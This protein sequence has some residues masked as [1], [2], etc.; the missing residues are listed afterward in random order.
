M[1]KDILPF[2]ELNGQFGKLTDHTGEE[3]RSLSLPKG[4]RYFVHNA[5][6]MLIRWCLPHAFVAFFFY[7]LQAHPLRWV[8][9]PF[10]FSSIKNKRPMEHSPWALKPFT[11]PNQD[12]S[13]FRVNPWQ[14]LLLPLVLLSM[15]LLMSFPCFSVLIRGKFF[16]FRFLAH[17]SLTFYFAAPLNNLC[18]L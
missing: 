4:A 15:S 14:I 17:P 16:C 18:K 11:N 8:G 6:R 3:P 12:V 7:C 2:L 1:L 13:S 10:S 9:L 5:R